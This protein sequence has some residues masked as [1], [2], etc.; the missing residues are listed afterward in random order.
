MAPC[1]LLVNH[2]QWRIA[3]D[4]LL[5]PKRSRFNFSTLIVL[6]LQARRALG[7][8]VLSTQV[9]T[10][11]SAAGPPAL[12]PIA[13]CRFRLLDQSRHT[14]HFKSL[15]ISEVLPSHPPR[16]LSKPE[17]AKLLLHCPFALSCVSG[18]RLAASSTRWGRRAGGY[19][20]RRLQTGSS[21]WAE[22]V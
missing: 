3:A 6:L 8:L 18:R 11:S 9:S 20:G 19:R 15:R 12:R 17:I 4:C 7:K 10:A 1:W 14:K 5:S 2:F 21:L 16:L 13:K 22:V